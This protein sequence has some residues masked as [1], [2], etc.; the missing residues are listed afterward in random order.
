M[1]YNPNVSN[2]KIIK[3]IWVKMVHK[4]IYL[5]QNK[6]VKEKQENKKD[7]GSIESKLRIA[8]V[9]PIYQ[10]VNGLISQSKG[11]NVWLGKKKAWSNYMLSIR[12]TP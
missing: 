1:C 8:N 4:C 6:E 2:K 5:I 12:D 10:N 9:K 11:R 7:K 3:N